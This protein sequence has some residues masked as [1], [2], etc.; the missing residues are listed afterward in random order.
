M[1]YSTAA[2]F[3]AGERGPTSAVAR[4]A[5]MGFEF[6][7]AHTMTR[8]LLDT[9]DGRLHGAK[10]RLEMR[11]GDDL[12][13][14]LVGED[15]APA[16]LTVSCVPRFPDDLPPGPIRSRL[17]AI[18]GVRALLPIVRVTAT[19]TPATWYDSDGKPLVTATVHEDI[20]V[21]DNDDINL[22][23]WMIE[24][25]ELTGHAKPISKTHAVLDDLGLSHLGGDTLT[26]V[27]TV[28]GVDLAGF[29][30]STNVPLDPE[31]R[32]IDG[33]RTVLTNLADT[34]VANWQGT[35][36]Q[37][38]PE[39]LHDLRVAVRRTRSLLGQGK[40]VLPPT[41][42]ERARERFSWLGALTGL[43]RDLDVYL[44]EWDNYTSP[45]TADV[46]AVLEPVRDLL[47]RR[48]Q[49]AYATLM[50][51]L[52]SGEATAWMTTWQ[53]WLQE[54]PRDEQQGLHASL[55]LG[56]VVAKQIKR[57]Q[58][59]LVEGGRLIRPDT[60]ADQV[61]RLRKDAKKLRY[62]LEC[63]GS[64]LPDAPRKTF[65]KRLKAF[66]DNLGEHQDAEVHAAEL[67]AI[68]RELHTSSATSDTIFAIGQLT[69]RL[70]QRRIAA[71]ADF[72]ERFAAYDTKATQRALDAT[73]D[74]VTK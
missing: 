52:Q 3:A 5:E 15:I 73:L 53:T 36:D 65:V 25:D 58:A 19:C 7:N 64:L 18:V 17:A 49:S 63:F 71:R 55:P 74:G 14:I 61:H 54:P 11:E 57:A 28:I 27:A 38:D 40:D 60:P 12:K 70:D 16:H 4:L 62:L 72:A 2:T 29:S 50:Q 51:A 33:F 31:M 34:I 24:I 67:R 35:I 8:T 13:L 37:L 20:C 9:F 43:A 21:Y 30:G 22:P 39:F 45:L 66:Q 23:P 42:V 44:I 10:L 1:T 26:M 6:G 41:I 32:A 68:S 56:E 48:R 47:E 59:N 46:I 69:E